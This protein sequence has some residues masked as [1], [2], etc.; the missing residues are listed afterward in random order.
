MFGI[1]YWCFNDISSMFQ[2]SE[3]DGSIFMITVD[4][5]WN[6]KFGISVYKGGDELLL[7]FF[8]F[9]VRGCSSSISI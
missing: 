5:V 9:S 7:L 6:F 3:F 1:G 2:Y 8:F 4:N